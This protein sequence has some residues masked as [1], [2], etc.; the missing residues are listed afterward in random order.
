[1]GEHLNSRTGRLSRRIIGPDSHA[2]MIRYSRDSRDAIWGGGRSRRGRGWCAI[3]LMAVALLAGGGD[4]EIVRARVPSKDVSK[5]FPAGTELRVMPAR[6]FDSLVVS[7]REGLLRQRAAEPPR[8]IRARHRARLNAGV[9]TGQSELVIESARSGPAEFILDP[10]TPAILS[11]PATARVVGARDSGKASLWIDQPLTQTVVLDWELRP[12]SHANGWSFALELPGNETTTLNLEAPADWIPSCRQ[13]RRRGPLN[14]APG[15]DQIVWEVEPEA[16]TINVHLDKAGAGLSLVEAKTWVSGSTQVDLRRTADRSGGLANW[17]TEWRLELDPRNPGPLRIE[18]DPGL[19]LIDVKGPAVQGYRSERLAN[20]TRLVVTLDTG[21]A[22]STEL[23]ILAHAQVPSEGE[24]EIPGLVPL[25]AIWTGGATTVLL[26][27]F[28]VLKECREKAGRLVVPSS[29]E[30]VSADRLEFKSASPRSIAALVFQGPRPDT[31]CAVKGRLFVTDSSVGL[32]CELNCGIHARMVPDLEIDLGPAW[33]PDRVVI[34]GIDDPVAWHSSVSSSGVTRL[35]V[36]L[37]SSAM[38]L[39]ELVVIVRASSSASRGRGPLQL[40]RVRLAGARMTDEAWVTWVDQGTMI[41]PTVARGLAWLDPREVPGLAG[42]PR[43]GADLREALAWRWINPKADARVDRERIEQQPGASFRLRSMIDPTGSRL[44]IDGRILVYAGAG[45]LESVP[46]YIDRSDGLLQPWRYTDLSGA[47]IDTIP[48]ADLDRSRLGFPKEGLARRLVVKIADHSEKTIQFHA[49]YAWKQQGP[50][51][52]ALMPREYLFRGMIVVEAP[53]AMQTQLKTVG[54]RRIATR[55]LESAGT[56]FDD[57][58][59]TADRDQA[60]PVKQ[61]MVDAF[62]YTEEGGRLE[63]VTEPLVSSGIAGLVREAVLTTSVDLKGTLLNRLRMLVSHGESRSLDLVVPPGLTLVRVRRDGVDLTPARLPAGL[64]I[65]LTESGPGSR[66]SSII[67]DYLVAKPAIANGGQLWPDVP[68]VALP[69]L[70]F[71]W[72]VVTTS[73]WQATDSGPGLIATDADEISGWPYADLGLPPRSWSLARA[74]SQ[75]TAAEA[76]RLLD[77]RLAD[78]VSADLTFAEW[79]C[80]LDAGPWPV[81][82]DRIALAGAGIGPK[83]QCIPAAAMS[84]PRNVV[85]ATLKQYGL[86]LVPFSDAFVITTEVE[87]PRLESTVRRGE[88]FTEALVW[89]SD[90]T[91]RFQSLARWRGEQS[92]RLIVASA[93]DGADRIKRPPGWLTWRFEG[94]GWPKDDAFV[95]LIDAKMRVVTGWIIAGACILTWLCVGRWLG[96]WRLVVMVLAIGI[97]LLGGWLLPWRY[98]SGSAGVYIAALG[99]LVFELGRACW[100]PR[101][102]DRAPGRSS[103]LLSRRAAGAAVCLAVVV[104]S[105][106]RTAVGQAAGPGPAILALFPYD[107]PFDPARPVSDVILRLAD[108]QHLKLLAGSKKVPAG[109]VVRAVAAVHRVAWGSALDG[110]VESEFELI[111]SGNAP[112]AWEFPVSH[113]RD[114]QV[115]LDGNRLPISIAPGGA[116]GKVEFSEA[117]DHLLQIRRSVATKMEDGRQCLRLPVNAMP[118]AR[119]LV[120]QREDGHAAALMTR[121]GAEVKPDHTL[122]G[123]LGPADLVQ[124]CRG[125]PAG[126]AAQRTQGNVEGLLLWD[127]TPAG[128]QVRARFTFHQT[129]DRATIR[130][131]HQQ[132]LIL[133]SVRVNGLAGTFCEQDAARGEWTLH[134]DPPLQSGSMIELNCWLPIESARRDGGVKP[135]PLSAVNGGQIRGLPQLE[136]VGVDRYSGALGVRRPGDW[137]GRFDP[138]PDTDPISDESFVESW[139]AL[140]QEPLTLCGTSRFVRECRAVLPTGLAPTRVQVKPTVDLQIESGRIAMTVDAELGE[141][142]GHLRRIEVEVPE[143]IQIIDVTSEGLTDWVTPGDRRLHLMFDRPI[144]RPKRHLRILAWIPIVE[145]PLQISTGQHRV[146]T[147]WFWWG[148]VESSTGF[149][150]ISSAVKPE[151]RGSTG[152]TLISSESS[153]AVVTASPNHRS[154]YRVDDPR[155]LGEILW[156]PPPARVSVAIES[157]MTIH[158]DSAEWVAVLRYDV[159]G[160]ALDAIHLK[161]PAAWAAGVS[162]HF[163]NGDAQLTKETRGPDAFWTITPARPIWGSQRFVLRAS[164]ALDSEPTI[165]HPEI[166]PRGEGVV[167]AYLSIINATGRPMPIDNVVGLDKIPYASKFRAREFARFAGA[168][169]GAFRVVQKSWILKAQSPRNPLLD[170]DSG[171]SSARVAFAD[172]TMEL[173]PDR[174]ILGRAVY[175]TVPGSGSRLSFELP[176]DSSLLWATVDFNN[177]IP[178]RSATGT[179]SIACDL[180]RP[181]RIGLLW[182]TAPPA[183]GPTGASWPIAFLR[184]GA[185]PA[186]ALVSIHTPSGVAVREGDTGGLEVTGLARLEMA[187]ADWLSHCTGDLVAKLDRSSGRD[188]EKLVSLLI[189]HEM[190]LRSAERNVRWTRHGPTKDEIARVEHD[191]ALIRVARTTRDDTMRR[192]GLEEDL[193]SARIYLGEL[194]ARLIRPMGGIPE[195]SEPERVRLVGRPAS[196]VGVVP[197]I[198]G[199]SSAASLTLEARPWDAFDTLSLPRFVTA[200]LL[201]TILLLVIISLGRR[202][203][204]NSLALVTALGLAGYTGGPLILA[205]GMGLA[206]AGWRMNRR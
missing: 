46:L 51:P 111:A 126:P 131:A 62:T 194:P 77:E 188:H 152:L 122:T 9:L 6:E 118:T 65:P 29:P 104:Q 100:R 123:R 181:S 47:P 60:A 134:V 124:V 102:S 163:S 5:W 165:V 2:R 205:G 177:A 156:D 180:D 195:P 26:D 14:S 35:D 139:G 108:F 22:T 162:L 170:R 201:F 176:P 106:D 172:L 63:L 200:M 17:K 20:S 38:S 190:A 95:F 109:P 52:L 59:A 119:V 130:F 10:W 135:G 182:R 168:A 90:R 67:L 42:S 179:S 146:Q 169:V 13:G 55:A 150:T 142:S 166:T 64:S 56:D 32:E 84:S 53:K 155:K 44:V 92:P 74:A 43:A 183:V 37:P 57:E 187:R 138:L 11:A 117:G 86:T 120:E 112:F 114:V 129:R 159:T 24:W 48:L 161:L 94:Q 173:L 193:S 82:V 54:L 98:A 4:P 21:L 184:A 91:D 80:R 16:G 198:E 149:L 143:N 30:E 36:T 154:T 39:K 160:G 7:A 28:H 115:T 73:A 34:R 157:Q 125:E 68:R 99:L 202:N 31:S 69:C 136:P 27:E 19:E 110:L 8:L 72:E 147:P 12:R 1:M 196:L 185:G 178:L 93:P 96:R 58:V 107:G 50:I 137:T 197:G 174:S 78:S 85:R 113:S 66:T 76:L 75:R 87:V 121:G 101:A 71:V 191:L 141:L 144:T 204:P 153:G 171:D 116:T 105:M 18:L 127:I 186:T 128:D 133:R 132:G 158:P 167:D 203:W 89:G 79:F 45:P 145:N 61:T 70:S 206:I 33:L 23:V 103:S 97:C 3:A 49:E 164:R 175:D 40:P 140:P 151:M 88:L 25:D 83:S 148:G 192:A 199:K 81:V 41:Q 15:S 189:N